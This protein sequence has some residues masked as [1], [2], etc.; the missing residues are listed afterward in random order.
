VTLEATFGIGEGLSGRTWKR[1]E[2]V[3]VTDL[4][5][6]DDC[7]R[8]PAA[9]RAGVRSG[10]CFP[11]V[12]DGVV[13]GTMD[14]FATETLELRQ[15]RLDTLRAVAVLVSQACE[16]VAN[17][18]K[19]AEAAEDSAAVTT[20]LR[21]VSRA[22]TREEALRLALDGIRTGFGWAY[23]S[24]WSVDREAGG[25]PVRG[26]PAG[27]RRRR[28]RGHHGLP[29]HR[30]ADALRRAGGGV[31]QHRVPPRAGARAPGVRPPPRGGRPRARRVGPQRGG[32]GA[33][34][35]GGRR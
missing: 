19:H 29:G 16:R 1:A 28:G 4:G 31:A 35:D 12:Q 5:E 30:H 21:S 33:G 27:P 9:Q 18:E 2:L 34:R 8:A 22:T 32:Q 25:R 26:V 24:Y 10:V 23:A 20:V 17:A 6:A 3:F 14:L 11:I 7:V 15:Q 13:V